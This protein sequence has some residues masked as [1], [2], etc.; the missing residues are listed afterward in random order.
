MKNYNIGVV[1]GDVVEERLENMGVPDIK[2]QPVATLEQNFKK[3]EYGRI[4]LIGYGEV[5]MEILT[6]FGYD[7]NEYE[8]VYTIAT[9][10]SYV[11]FA[12]NLKTDDIIINK[13]QKAF[14]ELKKEGVVDKIINSYI[15]EKALD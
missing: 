4:D 12:L 3:L 13:L 11:Y 6:D 9:D 8:K 2:I 1:R 5:A 14:D 15:E 10:P 7:I